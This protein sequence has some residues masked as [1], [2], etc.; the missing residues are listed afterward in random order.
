MPRTIALPT[1]LAV[2]LTSGCAPLGGALL[3]ASVGANADALGVDRRAYEIDGTTIAAW[4]RE[5]ADP[6]LALH[7]FTDNGAGFLEVAKELGDERG[8]IIPDLLGHGD[9]DTGRVPLTAEAQA[10]KMGDLL[11]ALGVGPAHAVGYSM[12]GHV[13]GVLASRRGDLVRSVTFV[14]SSGWSGETPSD[15]DLAVDAGETPFNVE[16][17]EDFDAF[18]DWLLVDGGTPDVPG[19]VL[20]A[21]YEDRL[22]RNDGWMAIGEDYAPRRHAM[23][24]RLDDLGVPS[25]G[26]FCL[27]DRIIDIS[28]ADELERRT[29][30]HVERL[31]GCGHAIYFEQP[32]ATGEAIA[33]FLD[34]VEGR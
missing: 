17:R 32:Q 16:S 28:V 20:D 26:V 7:G 34:D 23:Q 2:L 31:E 25:K 3:A 1:T 8:L 12:G 13:A 11:D 15:F 19:P 24:A 30:A 21:M 22:A 10:D 5:G 29:E 27:A 9:S 4:V 6:L 18:W 33:S 14:A